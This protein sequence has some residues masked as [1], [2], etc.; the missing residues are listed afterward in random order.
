MRTRAATTSLRSRNSI[1]IRDLRAGRLNPAE[2]EVNMKVK[3]IIAVSFYG[4]TIIEC[5]DES[6]ENTEIIAESNSA[7][8]FTG[9]DKAALDEI[10]ECEVI[11]IYPACDDIPTLHIQIERQ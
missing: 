3:E 11:G 10:G 5:D 8:S 1:T 2:S 9:K 6:G 4:L 7:G